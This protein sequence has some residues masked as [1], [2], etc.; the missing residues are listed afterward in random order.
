MGQGAYFKYNSTVYL[1]GEST[2]TK[3]EKLVHSH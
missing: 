3:N 2:K 1:K